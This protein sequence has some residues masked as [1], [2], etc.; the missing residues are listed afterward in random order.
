MYNILSR[1]LSNWLVMQQQPV[2]IHR[3]LFMY[4]LLPLEQ[5][6]SASP[7][8]P[9]LIQSLMLWGSHSQNHFAATS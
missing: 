8:L 3:R 5:Q 4:I 2:D 6:F 7:M 9:L 1:Y